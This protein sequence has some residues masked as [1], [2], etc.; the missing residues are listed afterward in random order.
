MNIKEFTSLHDIPKD[1]TGIC[2][3]GNKTY[4]YKEGEFHREDG[5]AIEHDNGNK[6]W[7]INGKYHREDGPA[8]EWADGYKSWYQNGK[9]H[10]L[11]GPAMEWSN[12]RKEWYQ[13]GVL[14]RLDGPAMEYPN[15]RKE[16]YINGKLHRED[17][18]AIEHDNGDKVWYLNGLRHR[19][20]GPARE[21]ANGSKEWWLDNHL[22]DEKEF[23][24]KM[25]EKHDVK[26]FKNY[27]QVPMNFTG[28]CD[29]N[30]VIHY[31]KEGAIHREDGPAIIYPDGLQKEWYLDN[32]LH[33]EDGPAIEWADGHKEWYQNNLLHRE[34]G[35]AIEY[36][37]GSKEWYINGEFHRENGPAIESCNGDNAW[38]LRNKEYTK[39]D[40]DK[41]LNLDKISNKDLNSESADQI[42]VV[43]N[44]IQEKSKYDLM[45]KICNKASYRIL[46]EQIVIGIIKS[47]KHG[48]SKISSLSVAEEI[49]TSSVGKALV[50]AGIG[51][52]L[53]KFDYNNEHI[54]KISEEMII[55]SISTLENS[56]FD[57]LIASIDFNEV[58]K[59]DT[60]VRIGEKANEQEFEIEIN[61]NQQSLSI[62]QE[63]EIEI[64]NNQQSLSI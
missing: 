28:I 61:N 58:Q 7:F 38:Y 48:L 53:N 37:D 23:N 2:K 26:K 30:S 57:S 15:G 63:F 60:F 9:R 62:E 13:N 20:D 44:T 51:I 12:G 1:F 18:P 42:Q 3:A 35:P 8:C 22:Y 5:P 14:H 41:I 59:Q 27:R 4:H 46:S 56:I 54:D 33:R 50:Q 6:E 40:F 43:E 34:D 55:S 52:V 39:E 45:I 36:A 16:W 19:T 10:R 24:Y 25:A 47:I 49:I 32:E 29:I 17:G 21:Y 11:D 64:N 31:Y